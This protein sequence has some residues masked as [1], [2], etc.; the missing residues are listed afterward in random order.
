MKPQLYGSIDNLLTIMA[1]QST[2]LLNKSAVR[3]GPTALILASVVSG[4]AWYF[5][6]QRLKHI[7]NQKKE[8]IRRV[9]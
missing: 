7:T 2:K 9:E 4:F 6:G 8:L 3:R 5:N 1:E